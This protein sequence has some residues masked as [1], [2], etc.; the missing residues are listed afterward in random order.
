ML[1]EG[2]QVLRE[3]FELPS[4]S[5]R[6]VRSRAI[7]CGAPRLK[8]A[9]T[10]AWSKGQAIVGMRKLRPVARSAPYGVCKSGRYAVAPRASR[11]H[12]ST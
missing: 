12:E 4:L 5:R 11:P 6:V 9:H 1:R 10:A 2:L 7:P 8:S 3:P